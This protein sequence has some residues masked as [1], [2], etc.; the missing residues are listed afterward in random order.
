VPQE[1]ASVTLKRGEGNEHRSETSPK[2]LLYGDGV[3]P[4]SGIPQVCLRSVPLSLSG[5]LTYLTRTQEKERQPLTLIIAKTTLAARISNRRFLLHNMRDSFAIG[6]SAASLFQ[7]SV[8]QAR[9]TSPVGRVPSQ[10]MARSVFWAGFHG[11]IL[12]ECLGFA[13]ELRQTTE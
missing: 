12:D 2:A 10:Q 8:G 3:D 9:A 4:R 1:A 13:Q 7:I 11:L 6:L 5:A